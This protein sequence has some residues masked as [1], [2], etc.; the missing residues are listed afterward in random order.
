MAKRPVFE[1]QRLKHVHME[2]YAPG[3]LSK[4]EPRTEADVYMVFSALSE[5]TDYQYCCG[6][7]KSLLARLGYK[8]DT[9][10]DAIRIDRSTGQYLMAEFK[11]ASREFSYNHAPEDVDVLVCW[12]YNEQGPGKLP[13]AVVDLRGLLERAVKEGDIDI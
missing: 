12:D 5:Y 9:K 4:W 1:R 6:A 2:P 8:A 11:M 3:N 7:S 13:P 10:P